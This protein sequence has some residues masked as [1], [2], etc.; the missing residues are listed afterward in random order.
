MAYKTFAAIDVGSYELAMKIFEISPKKGLREIDHIR[1]RIELG[2][3]T[4]NTGKI[5]KERVEE[6]CQILRSFK[7]IMKS[8]RVEEYKAYGT[9]AIRETE[10]TTIVLDMIRSGTGLNV[11]VISN[12]EQRFLDYKAIA[13]RGETFEEVIQK[14]TVIVDVGGGS[15]Q[16]S[17][18][19]REVLIGT[20]N[21]RLGLLRLRER[22]L[23]F[24][25]GATER[26]SLIREQVDNQF[27]VMKR[28]YMD[29]R[30][31]EN[32]I[33][34]DDYLS[35][36]MQRPELGFS[37]VGFMTRKECDNL[38]GRMRSESIM[39][40]ARFLGISEER[41]FLLY[42]SLEMMNRIME[43]LE[44]R[45]IWAPAVCLCDGIAYEYA[46]K[47]RLIKLDHDFEQDIL[48]CAR[49][50]A[51]R[52]KGNE[53]R[54]VLMENTALKIFDSTKKVHGLKPRHRLLLQL[55]AR[56][57]DCGKYISMSNVGECGYSIIMSNEIIGLSHTEREIVANIVK[58]NR[59]DFEY[60]SAVRTQTALDRDS[61][62]IVAKLSAI[63]KITDGLVRSYREKFSE[64]KTTLKDRELSIVINTSED[65]TLELGLLGPK[66]DFFEE[67][68]NVR[69]NVLQKRI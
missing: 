17:L 15:T 66:A 50:I 32:I 60:Y 8:Y 38:V 4:Y 65:L 61:Y 12:S 19:D 5:N 11:D 20:Q 16:I 40:T 26:M 18:F 25:A 46:E 42:I 59:A 56:L 23:N 7:E 51:E 69:V 31:I 54:T 21:L 10:N 52:F 1:H 44:I 37:R 43:L 2:T 28:L 53:A 6:V 48:A 33:F 67:V 39:D 24:Q 49:N 29:G 27:E 13:S 62:L 30:K 68:F 36:I 35:L 58:Y 14:G 9:S 41:A 64:V 45:M 47:N 34:V 3:D 55:A 22:L 63:L 57:N